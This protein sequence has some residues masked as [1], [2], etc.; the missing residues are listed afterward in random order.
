MLT[1]RAGLVVVTQEVYGRTCPDERYGAVIVV[2]NVRRLHL[3]HLTSD[4]DLPYPRYE[5]R[6]L[7]MDRGYA[8]KMKNSLCPDHC[9][10]A[11]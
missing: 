7:V 1:A 2:V 8:V 4:T 5:L 9:P 6:H 11:T 3:L 10:L